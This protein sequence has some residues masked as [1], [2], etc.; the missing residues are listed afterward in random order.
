MI[1]SK[2]KDLTPIL[3]GP[4]EAFS[5]I[6]ENTVNMVL[7]DYR[8]PKLNGLQMIENIKK[9]KQDIPVIM[10]SGEPDDSLEKEALKKGAA[11]F[12]RKPIGY[13]NIR[14]IVN[15]VADRKT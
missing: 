14:S 2:S 13:E 8:M 5:Y 4:E 7:T 11:L 12:M 9:L 1:N 6:K 10:I 15:H 3:F